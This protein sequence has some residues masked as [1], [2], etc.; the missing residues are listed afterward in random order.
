MKKVLLMTLLVVVSLTMYAQ[1]VDLRR[2][3]E[4]MGTAETELTPDIIYI[5]ISLKEYM[6]GKKKVGI[7]ALERALQTA[8]LK[9]GIPK[10]NFMVNDIASY[11][12]T[13]DRKSPDYLASKQY[14]IKVSDLSKW[15]QLLAGVEAKGVQYSAVDSY[16]YSKLESVKKELKI[17]AIKSAR[18]KA[19]YLA[20][21]IG[22]K[23]GM[24]IEINEQ[25]NEGYSQPVYRTA[26]LM[27]TDAVGGDVLPDIDFKKIKL[28][29]QIRAVFELK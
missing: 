23:V 16:D 1:Q 29:A 13:W 11:N 3:I 27:K 17:Q 6:D 4:V 22:E 26:M 28:N 19:V 15:N 25:N 7:E 14:R 18:D 21:A 8:V 24:A 2:K 10:E 12:F 5:S 20:E 9:A